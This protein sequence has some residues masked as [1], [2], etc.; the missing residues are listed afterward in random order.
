ME[1]ASAPRLG[2]LLA[3]LAGDVVSA[4]RRLDAAVAPQLLRHLRD[5]A[6]WPAFLAE[7]VLPLVLRARRFELDAMLEVGRAWEAGG[8]VGL[9]P[10]GPAF[11]ARFGGARYAAVRLA[12]VVEAV[13]VASARD[14]FPME[15][16]P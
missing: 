12:I 13:P 8:R 1:A 15:A 4:Q 5:A 7:S 3:Q 14:A 10:V 6:G 9:L 16:A 2:A 11:F